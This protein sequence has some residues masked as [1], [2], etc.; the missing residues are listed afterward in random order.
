MIVKNL[1]VYET[2]NWAYL[3]GT[4]SKSTQSNLRTAYQSRV[5]G[6]SDSE[7]YIK[8]KQKKIINDENIKLYRVDFESGWIL[9]VYHLYILLKNKIIIMFKK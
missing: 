6:S 8:N 1:R 5:R 2:Y 3:Y 9:I 7:K 4:L